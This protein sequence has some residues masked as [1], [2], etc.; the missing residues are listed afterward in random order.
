MRANPEKAPASL[1]F[2]PAIEYQ[3]LEIKKV[4][5]PTSK[6]DGS[7]KTLLVADNEQVMLD[8]LMSLLTQYGFR[9]LTANTGEDA[10]K[11][12]DQ[13]DGN[14][15]MVILD[16]GMPGK[17]GHQTM[18]ELF[19]SHPDAK[20]IITSGFTAS[21]SAQNLLKD[22]AFSFLRKPYKFGDL[23]KELKKAFAS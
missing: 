4:H 20:V 23:I 14:I 5:K 19:D 2:S 7:T 10:L 17:G 13:E 11:I 15:D 21:N 8:S 6:L 3:E 18:I 16:L 12:Y 1:C 9:V 22:G